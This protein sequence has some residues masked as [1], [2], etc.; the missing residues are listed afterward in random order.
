VQIGGKWGYIDKQGKIIIKPQFES[1]K[2]FSDGMA[3]VSKNQDKTFGYIDQSG[4][5]IIEPGFQ[6]AYPFSEGLARVW[7]DSRYYFI[8]KTG[9][10]TL[11]PP[12]EASL[13]SGFSE[14]L[15]IF[16]IHVGGGSKSGYMDKTGKIIL[17]P[18]YYYATDFSE[19]LAGVYPA[20]KNAWV[21]I[22]KTGKIILETKFYKLHPYRNGIALVANYLG[23]YKMDNNP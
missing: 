12:S 3:V 19:G 21:Y 15:A 1:A 5:F 18:E 10:E 2:E 16:M 4:K 13:E 17:K 11:K 22:D 23:A 20:D 8:D 7:T 6:V 9:K 14:G